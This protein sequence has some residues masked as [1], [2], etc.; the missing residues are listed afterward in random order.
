MILHVITASNEHFEHPL[1]Q[2]LMAGSTLHFYPCTERAKRA[3]PKS[4]SSCTSEA[5][6]T[7][8]L[9]FNV[10]L[11]KVEKV[12]S[13]LLQ[14]PKMMDLTLKLK[15]PVCCVPFEAWSGDSRLRPSRAVA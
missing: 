5:S 15:E 1:S 14:A 2:R 9:Q 10:V 13:I 11:W 4:T 6:A 12:Y 3:S 7:T 8:C